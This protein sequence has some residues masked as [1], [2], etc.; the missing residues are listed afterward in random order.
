MLTI[1]IELIMERVTSIAIKVVCNLTTEVS[2]HELS[3]KEIF[4]ILFRVPVCF[5]LIQGVVHSAIV[6]NRY[7]E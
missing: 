3:S 4:S 5:E 7:Q 6:Q 1:I 2:L